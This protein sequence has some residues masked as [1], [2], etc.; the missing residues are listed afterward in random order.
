MAPLS[1]L[2]YAH[3]LFAFFYV[4]ALLAAH[5]NVLAVRRT[6]E[7]GERAVLLEQNQRLSVFFSLGPLI[8]TGIVGNLLAAQ[9]GYRMAETRSLQVATALW[10]VLVILGAAIEIPTS[11]RLAALARSASKGPGAEPV[12]WNSSLTRWRIGNALQLAVFLGLLWIMIAP[13][14]V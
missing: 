11:A 6:K 12:G 1:I 2:K 7:W 4:A 5:W 9:S 13:W 14:R 10:L 3:E 8:G